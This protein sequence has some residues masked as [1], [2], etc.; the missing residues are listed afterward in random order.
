MKKIALFFLSLLVSFFLILQLP[1][2]VSPS[3]NDTYAYAAKKENKDS[4]ISKLLQSAVSAATRSVV[5]KS[6][7]GALALIPGPRD[8]KYVIQVV[9]G[10]NYPLKLVETFKRKSSSWPLRSSIIPSKSLDPK[11]SINV[12]F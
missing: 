11:N 10:T 2:F 6:I 5:D 12:D 1:A 4:L 8:H 7:E 3:F 9:N